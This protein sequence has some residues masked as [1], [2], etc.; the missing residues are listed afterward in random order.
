MV[1]MQSWFDVSHVYRLGEI[2]WT[3]GRTDAGAYDNTTSAKYGQGV[4]TLKNLDNIV[5]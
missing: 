4:K 5:F 3:N 1:N 2:G